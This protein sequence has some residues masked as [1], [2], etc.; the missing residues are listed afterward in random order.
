MTV[1]ISTMNAYPR[2]QLTSEE[3]V[4]LQNFLTLLIEKRPGSIKASEA[5]LVGGLYN[6][7]AVFIQG[8]IDLEETKKTNGVD[9]RRR[10][11]S[12][13]ENKELSN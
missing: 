7:T 5:L 3:T 8:I 4:F 12:V 13:P 2:L 6:K 1:P 10:L 11:T 9:H